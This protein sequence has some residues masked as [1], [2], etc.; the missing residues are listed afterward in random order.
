MIH[1]KKAFYCD[2]PTIVVVVVVTQH[3]PRDGGMAEDH[4]ATEAGKLPYSVALFAADKQCA[5]N[6]EP[7][8]NTKFWTNTGFLMKYMYMIKV[9][10]QRLLTGYI[11]M[12]LR[13]AS[14]V[15]SPA[16]VFAGIVSSEAVNSVGDIALAIVGNHLLISC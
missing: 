12:F 2:Y 14:S 3:L 4:R 11:N 10:D 6:L 5:D 15:I 8:L 1:R 13:K 7:R 9:Y 16:K